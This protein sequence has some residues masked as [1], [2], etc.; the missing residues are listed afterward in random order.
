MPHGENFTVLTS[1]L[2]DSPLASWKERELKNYEKEYEES[3][4]E[5]RNKIENETDNLRQAMKQ[6][7]SVQTI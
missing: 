1:E 4:E 3:V 5:W 2:S 6:L 7:K